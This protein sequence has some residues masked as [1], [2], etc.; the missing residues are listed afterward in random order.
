MRLWKYFEWRWMQLL[1]YENCIHI[2][3]ICLK[4]LLR[5]FLYI[6]FYVFCFQYLVLFKIKV[7]EYNLYKYQAYKLSWTWVIAF[8]LET[9][10]AQVDEVTPIKN[11]LRIIKIEIVIHALNSLC[12]YKELFQKTFETDVILN[13]KLFIMFQ[14]W[15]KHQVWSFNFPFR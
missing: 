14:N 3:F 7:C 2:K 1:Y 10:A 4:K 12:L 8:E 9:E 11:K 13:T 6:H 15:V 5:E